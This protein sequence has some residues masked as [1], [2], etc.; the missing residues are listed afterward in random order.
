MRLI[1]AIHVS[2]ALLLTMVHAAPMPVEVGTVNTETTPSSSV[3]AQS[4]AISPT[5]IFTALPS[6]SLTAEDPEET[7]TEVGSTDK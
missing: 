5:D 1:S 7:D 6:S 2:A 3:V 4:D